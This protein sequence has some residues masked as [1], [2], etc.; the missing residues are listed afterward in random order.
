M[1][2]VL[3]LPLFCLL[4]GSLLLLQA[5]S[6]FRSSKQEVT[7]EETEDVELPD[8]IEECDSECPTFKPEDFDHCLSDLLAVQGQLLYD[9]MMVSFNPF[10]QEIPLLQ[11]MVAQAA[12]NLFA[13]TREMGHLFA[14]V[15]GRQVGDRIE[16][17]FMTNNHL[18]LAYINALKCQ[19][20]LERKEWL[21]QLYVNGHLF[22]EFMNIMNSFFALQ[23]EK[24]MLDEHVTLQTEIASA[25]MEGDIERAEEL[26]ERS[27]AQMKELAL[28]LYRAIFIQM[29]EM[30]CSWNVDECEEDCIE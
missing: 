9:V 1:K 6:Y 4:I 22:V 10:S 26:K 30:V 11:E 19:E 28:H 14:T 3:Y 8:V 24:Y 2:K 17:Y 12:T 18:L 27:I 7:C 29:T 5:C 25:L 13:N 15:Y 16:G 20:E 23:P 21:R